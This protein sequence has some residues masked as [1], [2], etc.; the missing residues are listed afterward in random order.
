MRDGKFLFSVDLLFNTP[1]IESE[2]DVEVSFI[3][4]KFGRHFFKCSGLPTL[5]PG[6][7]A[8]DMNSKCIDPRKRSSSM[9]HKRHMGQ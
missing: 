6:T 1:N 5:K 4:K 2:F 8:I 7:T 3:L 9:L